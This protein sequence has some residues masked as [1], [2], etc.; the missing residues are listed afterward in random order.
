MYEQHLLVDA[1]AT[2]KRHLATTGNR[3]IHGG[4]R[5]LPIPWSGEGDLVILCM[6]N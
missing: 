6:Q 5:Y 4:E 1:A 2:C 3:Y